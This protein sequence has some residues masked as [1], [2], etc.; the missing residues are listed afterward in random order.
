MKRGEVWWANFPQPTGRRPVVIL[1]R[2]IA[3]KVREYITVAEVTRTV[4]HIPTE[5][6]LGSKDGLPQNCVVNLDVINTIP[7]A[8]LDE[9]ITFLSADKLRAVEQAVKFALNL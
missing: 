5:V 4:R 2:D 1:S 8:L 7:K 9:R 6:A 3:V